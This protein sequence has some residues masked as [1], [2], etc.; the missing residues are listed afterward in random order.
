M[1][2][3]SIRVGG[4][5]NIQDTEIRL[6]SLSAI[7]APNGFGKS[8][9][10]RAISMG[11]S[12]L[13]SDSYHRQQL[14]HD[15]QAIPV[16]KSIAHAPYKME[17]SGS[18]VLDN[19]TMQ[20]LYR[21]KLAWGN[22]NEA[23]YVTEEQLLVKQIGDQRYRKLIV[24]DQKE[25]FLM[26]SAPTGRCNRLMAIEADM[27]A[28]Q[29]VAGMDVTY[30]HVLIKAIYGL[31]IPNLETLDNP[32]SYFSLDGKGIALLGGQTLSEYLYRLRDE[33]ENRYSILQDGLKQLIPNVVELEPVEVTLG[34]GH[35]H[36]YDIRVT[37]RHNI[38]PTS[39]RFLSSGS[40]RMI[41]LFT[42]CMAAA[43]QSIPLLMME[44]PEN[45][46]HPRLMENLLL[47]MRG[48][49]E[50]CQILITSHSPYLMRYLGEKQMYL[51]LPNEDGVARFGRIRLSKLKALRRNA[52]EM[53]LTLGEYMFDFMLDMED[54]Q[55]MVAEYLGE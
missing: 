3:S 11:I 43:K 53:E 16:N 35:S 13:R 21:L 22:E 47:A 31:T 26:Q 8:N 32:E 39:I 17:I 14:L 19:H 27:P 5:A 49:A 28:I 55:D 34:D 48:Y 6:E 52:G 51:G 12:Y 33:D 42:L 4:F 24:R 41:F 7:I 45:S 25:S 50:Q 20:F 46:V 36:L 37:E 2:I 29:R 54:R 9:L 10:L 38:Q 1:Y 44:E 18:M 15:Q 40:K 23:G 30:L